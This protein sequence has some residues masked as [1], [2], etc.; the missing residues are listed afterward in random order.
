MGEDEGVRR[1]ARTVEVGERVV[2]SDLG[3]EKWD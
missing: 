2:G 3:I 1:S